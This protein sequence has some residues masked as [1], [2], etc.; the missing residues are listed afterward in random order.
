MGAWLVMPALGLFQIDGGTRAEPVYEIGSPL[1]EKAVIDLGGLYG[2]GKSFAI[3]ARNASREHVY[4]QRAT[5]NGKS[6]D[7]F[8]FPEKELL[9]GGER[10]EER[11]EGRGWGGTWRMRG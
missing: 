11:G 10:A 2:R 3:E 6:L 7:Q 8:W 4:V 5:L 1:F 9:A